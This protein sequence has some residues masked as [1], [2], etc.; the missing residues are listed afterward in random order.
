MCSSN[1][2]RESSHIS[3][4]CGGNPFYE[5][6]HRPVYTHEELAGLLEQPLSLSLRLRDQLDHSLSHSDQQTSAFS[7]KLQTLFSLSN[8]NRNFEHPLCLTYFL[9]MAGYRN[10]HTSVYSGNFLILSANGNICHSLHRQWIIFFGILLSCDPLC[11]C[12]L[13]TELDLLSSSTA[14]CR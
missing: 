5:G 7:P 13:A 9:F 1:T 10:L 2:V 12:Y 14:L 8:P 3:F 11:W 4:V 6:M